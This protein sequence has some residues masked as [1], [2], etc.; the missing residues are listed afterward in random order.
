MAKLSKKPGRRRARRNEP[1]AAEVSRYRTSWRTA[2]LTAA[3][4]ALASAVVFVW[5]VNP[6]S[7]LGAATRAEYSAM[8]GDADRGAGRT[9]GEGPSWGEVIAAAN[10]EYRA[11]HARGSQATIAGLWRLLKEVQLGYRSI[12]D[13]LPEARADAARD[14]DNLLARAA[15]AVLLDL[16]NT[17][18]SLQDESARTAI[19]RYEAIRA[20]IED[21][22]PARTATL[23]NRELTRTWYGVLRR[24]IKRPQVAAS[25]AVSFPHDRTELHY[26]VLPVIRER[27]AA[28]EGVL[29]KAGRPDEA[30]RC[31]RWS[32]Q[33]AIG[34]M[35][36]DEDAG[37]RLLCADL[38]A[39]SLA[40]R[41]A[42]A[43]GLTRMRRDFHSAAA[44]APIDLCDQAF[45]RA[46]TVAPV[47]YR[48]A[49][50]SLVLVGALTIA[51]V[52]SAVVFVLSCLVA[53]A[54]RLLVRSK[55]LCEEK[56]K[57][58]RLVWGVV[59]LGPALAVGCVLVGWL[60]AYGLYSESW[61]YAV[62][63]SLVA[64]GIPFAVVSAGWVMCPEGRALRVRHWA[65]VFLSLLALLPILLPPPAVAWVGREFDL[66]V[67]LGWVL[68]PWLCILVVA[69]LSCSPARWR[70]LARAA[71]LVWCVNTVA[72]LVILPFHQ[73]SDNRYQAAVVA[74]RFDEI[75][76][77]LGKDWEEK[78]LR[79]L[80]DAF[81]LDGP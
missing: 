36:S 46:P 71:A 81:A 8:A 17:S 7:M 29:R 50:Y 31:L 10:A 57:R 35:R 45:S 33:L 11:S 56:V 54:V 20:V 43:A 61:A 16:S 44:A 30:E 80:K 63:A 3:L 40:D 72:A 34:L 13:A 47:Q 39:R 41:P 70:T 18:S 21:P 37:T 75:S 22:A 59:S 1:N 32:V 65:T 49:F 5:V 6:L 15:Y 23:Y 60:E 62:V 28:L 73:V 24:F 79:P 12:Q 19:G 48:R 14:A 78:Y 67:G 4:A 66:R 53:L 27:L 55:T 77:R 68:I 42:L 52:G 26:E 2:F 74:G 58:R 9:A 76:A 64:S 25:L 51:G 38:L 69:A